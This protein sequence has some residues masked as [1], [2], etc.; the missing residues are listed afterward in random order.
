V[1][2]EGVTSARS[3]GVE[4]ADVGSTGSV[5]IVTEAVARL[6]EVHAV[7]MSAR[8]NGQMAMDDFRFMVM[9]EVCC[10]KVIV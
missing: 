4:M 8:A 6:E 5:E 2:E 1:T 10:S 9:K 3:V 7:N